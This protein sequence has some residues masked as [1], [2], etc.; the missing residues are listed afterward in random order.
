MREV[1]VHT[2]ARQGSVNVQFPFLV[3]PW[4]D[5]PI[6]IIG[7]ECALLQSSSR[8]MMTCN[9]YRPDIF[10]MAGNGETRCDGMLPDDVMLPFPAAGGQ[11][12]PHLD[13]HIEFT[14]FPYF[15]VYSVFYTAAEAV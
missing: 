1:L 6:E 2:W 13:I 14:S 8:A 4:E 15:L 3:E 12:P 11:D 7:M 5:E 9:S 10:F